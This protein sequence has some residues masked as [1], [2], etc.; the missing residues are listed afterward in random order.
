MTSLLPDIPLYVY[1]MLFVP[2]A[3][4]VFAAVW[5]SFEVRAARKWP[6]A[7]GVV[8]ES[9]EQLRMVKLLERIEAKPRPPF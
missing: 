2:I 7:P 8:V 4:I 5:K 1:F 3:M 9:T 6:S